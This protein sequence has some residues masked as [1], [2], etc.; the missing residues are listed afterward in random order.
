MSGY[1]GPRLF[2]WF[3]GEYILNVTLVDYLTEFKWKEWGGGM[4]DLVEPFSIDK[5][6]S[7]HVFPSSSMDNC[8]VH[9]RNSS[10]A[11][12]WKNGN[13]LLSLNS[14]KL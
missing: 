4:S 13:I 7:S 9:E 1:K 11:N 5:I 3:I 2:C 14:W 10:W 8:I 12:S 6:Q